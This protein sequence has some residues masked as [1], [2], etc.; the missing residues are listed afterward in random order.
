MELQID[1]NDAALLAGMRAGDGSEIMG[2]G[3]QGY[4]AGILPNSRP[5]LK[6]E[7]EPQKWVQCAKCSLWR[8]VC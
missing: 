4:A 3:L 8:K 5:G 1:L 2:R 6:P 7:D